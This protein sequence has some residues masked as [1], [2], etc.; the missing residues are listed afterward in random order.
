MITNAK[1]TRRFRHGVLTI[2]GKRLGITPEAVKKR[3]ERH[4][5]DTVKLC[6]A[7][8]VEMGKAEEKAKQLLSASNG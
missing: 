1:Q 8:E 2:A 4:K 3:I 6:L 5:L 7:I